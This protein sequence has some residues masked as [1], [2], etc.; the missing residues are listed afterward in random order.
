MKKRYFGTVLD[1]EAGIVV[2]NDYANL[3]RLSKEIGGGLQNDIHI[4]CGLWW[5]IEIPKL[6]FKIIFVILRNRVL[7]PKIKV[8]ILCNTEKELKLLRLFK[9]DSVY[10]NHNCF[11]DENI[12]TIIP[13]TKKKYDAVYNAVLNNFKRHSLVAATKGSVAFVTYRYENTSY[14]NHLDTI[15][16][17]ITWLNYPSGKE[18]V[19][20]D[21]EALVEIYNESYTGLALSAAEG[22]M[23]SSCEYLLCG[24]PVV[25]TRSKG[26]RD[27]FFDE[28][29]S[30]IAD[31][32]PQQ[33]ALAVETLKSANRDPM[34][35]RMK[36]ISRMKSHRRRFIDHVDKI[37]RAKGLQYGISDT[38][39]TWFVNKL[40]NELNAKELLRQLNDRPIRTT[41]LKITR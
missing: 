15:L 11:I 7:Y 41:G 13:G 1:A 27:V 31:A 22:A 30:I 35:I 10:C 5:S 40:R 29:N 16:K 36:A 19:F 25:S 33:I 23:Y 8:S 24:I 20:L 14:K 37:L 2:L 17:N 38:W 12:F 28:Y 6:L 3:H 39:D 26:G 9:I 21:N 18:P 32:V 4:I 34:A